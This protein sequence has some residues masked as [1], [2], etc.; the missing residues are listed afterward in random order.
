MTTRSACGRRPALIGA[1]TAMLGAA[2]PAPA[3]PSQGWKP[4]RTVTIVVPFAAGSGTDAITRILAQQLE[5]E[6]GQPV[7]V[8]NRAGANGSLA[9][10]QVA[11][12]A[13]DGLTLMMT[14]NTPH[15]ANPALMKR[16]DYDPV[17][18]FTPI[19]RAGNYTFWLVVGEASPVR[20]LRELLD[21]ARAR[22]G[23][24]TY[25]SGN[26]TGIV[27]GATIARMGGVEMTHVPYRSTPPAMT[28]VIAG[29]VS[30]MVV[31]VSASLGHVREGRLR[32]LGVTSR[33]RS[34]LVPDVPSLHEAGL[35]GFNVVA[36]AGLVGPARMPPEVV[37]SINAVFRRLW[38]RPETVQRLAGIGFEA[39]TS[40]PEEFAEFIRGEIAHWGSMVRA[41][42]IEP[43]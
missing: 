31:D 11:R 41:A 40:T 37:A 20:S 23:E 16:L 3:R 9:A 27:A 8:E 13:P 43:E 28:D 2:L 25:A 7:V 12:A 5:P 26:S 39:K 4:P 38:E 32:A 42:G 35:P 29:R 21:R 18:G 17:G 15:A 1:G 14:T 10:S 22:P 36:W 30:C 6:W 24:V 33:E 34:A 19:A